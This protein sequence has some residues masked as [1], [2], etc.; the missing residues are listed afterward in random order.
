M[1]LLQGK[2]QVQKPDQGQESII[3]LFQVQVP[4]EELLPLAVQVPQL[5]QQ[6]PQQEPQSQLHP[7][8]A[9]TEGGISPAK[10]SLSPAFR[11]CNV[12]LQRLC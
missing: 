10:G 4:R 5:Q 7:S 8:Q 12:L 6:V 9:A 11:R 1:A 3:L 2:E